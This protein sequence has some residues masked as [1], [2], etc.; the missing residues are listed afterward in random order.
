VWVRIF[1]VYGKG[2]KGGEEG[3]DE[4][5]LYD[6]VRGIGLAHT[7][8]HTKSSSQYGLGGLCSALFY[9]DMKVVKGKE[10]YDRGGNASRP[11]YTQTLLFMIMMLAYI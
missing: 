2:E 6:W 4:L 8:H 1:F 7:T 11:H 9:L 5:R 3:D 10:E